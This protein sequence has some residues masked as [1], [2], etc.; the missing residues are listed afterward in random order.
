MELVAGPPSPLKAV[1]PLPAIVLIVPSRLHDA[2]PIISTVSNEKIA[3]RIQI[4][5]ARGVQRRA[6]CR[7]SVAGEAGV[8]ISRDRFN[9]SIAHF[10]N[11]VARLVAYV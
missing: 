5:S 10:A 3:R 7:T 4:K 2:N 8:P 11:A 9:D 1:P 6:R